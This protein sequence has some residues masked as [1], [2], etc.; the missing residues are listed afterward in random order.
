MPIDLQGLHKLAPGFRYWRYRG[1]VT[2]YHRCHLAGPRYRYPQFAQVTA[3]GGVEPGW[4]CRV[5]PAYWYMEL[6]GLLIARVK[7]SCT[8]L[9]QCKYRLARYQRHLSRGWLGVGTW[10]VGCRRR[11]RMVHVTHPS[12]DNRLHGVRS[13]QTH[14][15]LLQ[16]MCTAL[17]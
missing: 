12:T 7:S 8:L 11:V 5:M 9:V 2:R 16:T 15:S 10:W 1:P 6:V 14:H 3:L 4:K 17:L 13:S